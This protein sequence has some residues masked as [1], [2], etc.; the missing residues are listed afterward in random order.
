M[1]G[2]PAAPVPVDLAYGLLDLNHTRR[3]ALLASFRT[4]SSFH[5]CP[6]RWRTARPFRQAKT[7]APCRHNTLI[8]AQSIGRRSNM[9]TGPLVVAATRSA[10]VEM[11]PIDPDR[12][13]RKQM[14]FKRERGALHGG[15]EIRP[16]AA[17]YEISGAERDGRADCGTCSPFQRLPA[18]VQR[19]ELQVVG[20]L[21]PADAGSGRRPAHPAGCQPVRQ[22]HRVVAVDVGSAKQAAAGRVPAALGRVAWSQVERLGLAASTRADV[23]QDAH[24]PASAVP[25]ELERE[26]RLQSER[27][28]SRR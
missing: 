10:Q 15:I 1:F 23:V 16:P 14:S 19:G 13:A 27:Y 7:S 5:V 9:I 18:L 28:P 4:Q 21:Q 12:S 26:R 22:G 6:T 2:K 3:L 20:V 8:G 25:S 17:H 11:Q 24:R